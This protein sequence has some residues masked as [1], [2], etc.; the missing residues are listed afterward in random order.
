MGC[1]RLSYRGTRCNRIG[2]QV[3]GSNIQPSGEKHVGC[4]VTGECAVTFDLVRGYTVSGD[5]VLAADHLALLTHLDSGV[6]LS[7]VD[8]GRWQRRSIEWPFVFVDVSAPDGGVFVLR[9]RCDGY[10]GLPRRG[11]LGSAAKDRG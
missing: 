7:G 5:G 4:F 11:P 8:R 1:T 10:P 2:L 6:F 9:L 3:A